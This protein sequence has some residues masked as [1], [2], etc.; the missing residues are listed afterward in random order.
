VRAGATAISRADGIGVTID[1][2]QLGGGEIR[3]TSRHGTIEERD[4]YSGAA[5]APCHQSLEVDER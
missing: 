5:A 4:T 1:G 3:M 2:V